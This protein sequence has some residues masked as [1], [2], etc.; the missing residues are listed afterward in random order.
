MS[1]TDFQ[2]RLIHI[3][4]SEPTQINILK[5]IIALGILIAIR[6]AIVKIVHKK[7]ADQKIIYRW[8][9]ITS[10]G[11]YA[12]LF[13]LVGG[14]WSKGLQSLATFFGLLSAGLAVALKD[15]LS[16][17]AGWL[18]IF[19]KEPFKIGHRIQIDTLVGDVIDI[20]FIQTSLL[21]VGNFSNSEQP[22]GRIV[23]LPNSRI[24]TNSLANYDL[25]FPYIWHEIDI[26]VTF[27]SDWVK[28]KKIIEDRISSNSLVY[29]EHSLQ[30]FKN[31][32]KRFLLPD[33]TI[34]PIIF[35]GVVDHGVKLSARFVCEP[36]NRRTIE[37]KVWEGVLEAFSKEEHIDFA[38]PTQRFY[39][40]SK[41]GKPPLH[42]PS[43][44][45]SSK[46]IHP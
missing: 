19:W 5:S 13:L 4:I 36:R 29:D 8:Q 18:Y 6:S 15:Y 45:N 14:I 1:F 35:T 16:N 46:G 22:T 23:F 27:E 44:Q 34:D 7:I 40:N 25:S 43:A 42:P 20:G 39:D 17:L 33:M 26:V 41:E 30:R 9:K 10:Y 24:F 21:E 37:Q 3:G 2:N 11:F 38:Y 28:A 32:S 12:S 31:Q